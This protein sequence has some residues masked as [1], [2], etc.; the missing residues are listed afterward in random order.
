MNQLIL[1]YDDR[2]FRT[3]ISFQSNR[4]ITINAILDTG[5]MSTSIPLNLLVRLVPDYSE[6]LYSKIKEGTV[7]LHDA[8]GNVIVGL[9]S[10]IRNICIGDVPIDKLYCCV[11]ES[12]ND[13]ALLGMDFITSFSGY[14]NS[15]S[16]IILQSFDSLSYDKNHDLFYGKSKPIEL[17]YLADN[18]LDA[19]LSAYDIM[20]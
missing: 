2:A 6:Y 14:F 5:A 11:Y 17:N 7:R 1:N 18:N 10:V 16:D 9:S 15:C 20:R 19:L 4:K 3:R 12:V 13:V 8:S